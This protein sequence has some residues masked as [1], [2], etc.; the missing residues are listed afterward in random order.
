MPRTLKDT[1]YAKRLIVNFRRVSL[2]L[3]LAA[4]IGSS[5][6][7]TILISEMINSVFDQLSV[8]EYIIIAVAA[9]VF[10]VL[11]TLIAILI[12]IV[13][14]FLDYEKEFVY[15]YP[16]HPNPTFPSFS[17]GFGAILFSFGG[18]SVF[19]TIQNDMKDRTKF[20]KSVVIGFGTILTLYFPI[21]LFG[22][23]Y[24]GDAVSDNVILSF[25]SCPSISV[26]IAFEIFNLLGTFII[27]LSPVFQALEAIFG[28]PSGRIKN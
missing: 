21:A 3:V 20:W 5:I 23:I 1:N 11:S 9:S 15:P 4:N 19:P 8:C 17:L 24:I 10:A 16:E 6:V 27:T 7:F 2:A 12:I 26:A 22:Y 25:D 13:K 28:V 14:I 18:M